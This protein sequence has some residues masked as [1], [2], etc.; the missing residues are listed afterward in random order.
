MEGDWIYGFLLTPPRAD[1]PYFRFTYYFVLLVRGAVWCLVG[2]CILGRS[3][4]EVS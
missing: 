1:V 3:L 4:L 2:R